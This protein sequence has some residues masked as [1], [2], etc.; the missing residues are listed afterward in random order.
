MTKLISKRKFKDE[1]I[2]IVM[3]P[4]GTVL[5][6]LIYDRE[7]YFSDFGGVHLPEKDSYCLNK[8]YNVFFFPH[9]YAIDF[10]PYVKKDK[11]INRNTV[12]YVT[13]TDMNIAL[14]IKPSTRIRNDKDRPTDPILQPC[15]K[16]QFCGDKVGKFY[17]PCFKDEF[18]E[19]NPDIVGS[20]TI[21]FLDMVTLKK[22]FWND[23]V[24]DFRKFMTFF[25]EATGPVGVPDL[26]LYPRR[27]R[28]LKEIITKRPEN[29]FKW[30][31]EHIEEFNFFPLFIFPHLGFEKDEQFNFLDKAFSPK[32]YYEEDTKSVYHL[33]I[34]KRTY[35]YQSIEYS[36]KK[37]LTHCLPVY[38]KNKLDILRKWNPQFIFQLLVPKPIKKNE[39]KIKTKTE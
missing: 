32:G 20:L 37:T 22:N 9:P 15:N 7:D 11:V 10:N 29:G 17:D 3:I 26:A 36:D 1:E 19:E 6:R 39:E 8:E 23:E 4:K 38:E 27:K 13:T 35:F 12:V 18:I 14:Y 16:V 25:Q 21:S 5:F 2:D 28:S 30:I 24:K 31:Q 34:D 33:T